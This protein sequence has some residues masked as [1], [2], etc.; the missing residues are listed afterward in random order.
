METKPF[1]L[2]SPEQIAK[3]YMGNKQ[4]IAAAA[5]M[6]TVDPTAAVLA[7]MFID[8]MR[9]AAVQEQQ[10]VSTVAQDVLSPSPS[11]QMGLG[12]PPPGMPPMGAPPP[13]G[14]PPQ[15]GA[16]APPP[17]GGMGAPAGLGALPP[18]APAMADGGLVDLPVPD[19][20]FPD[21]NYAGGGMVSFAEGDEVSVPADPY[22]AENMFGMSP[23]PMASAA[24]YDRLYA[25]QT[26]RREQ[27][28]AYYEGLMSPEAQEKGRKEDLY[29]MLAQI[30]FGMAG[31]NSPSFLQAAGQAANAAIP[32][33]VQAR[34]ERKA[35]QRQGLAALTSIEEAGNAEG[36]ARAEFSTNASQRAAEIANNNWNA[37]KERTF[38]AEQAELQRVFEASE[39]AKQRAAAARSGGG[40]GGGATMA[41]R[42]AGQIFASLRDNPANANFSDAQLQRQAMGT[43]IRELA[44]AEGGSGAPSVLGGNQISSVVVGGD[45]A[46]PARAN[47][48]AAPAGSTR[49]QTRAERAAAFSERSAAEQ[50]RVQAQRQA[51]RDAR[52]ARA[53]VRRRRQAADQRGA[54]DNMTPEEYRA[55]QARR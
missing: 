33:A 18:G 5:K 38:R 31:T 45:A 42:Y 16:G 13:M 15:M 10:P 34:R 17:M 50:R 4:K 26:A 27:T 37:E 9:S 35:E 11:P 40:G 24:T 29:T 32:G 14:M 1:S 46:A 43:A 28:A 23:D 19:N 8:R 30:G 54:R 21:D 55:S 52:E 2:Q 53:E 36:R 6:G 7:G 25:P 44:A 51:V 22:T 48:P 49:P 39:N 20:M 12:A 41:E 3:D 47:A